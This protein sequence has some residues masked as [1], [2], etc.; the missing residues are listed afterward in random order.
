MKYFESDLNI[1]ADYI[2][3]N[4]F[5]NCSFLVTGATG[6]IGSI[7][8]KSLVLCNDKYKTEIK[9]KATVRSLEKVKEVFS[10]DNF[11][12][13]EFIVQ[14][15]AEQL[16]C[17]GV[18]YLIHTATPTESKFFISNPVET[19]KAICNGSIAVLDFAKNNNV[20]GMVY[21]SSMEVFGSAHTS[22]E[23]TTED[24]LGYID[25]AN[26]RSCYSESKRLV[27]CAC[28]CY[29]EE[30]GVPVKV[31][32]LAQTFGAGISKK[33]NRVF[34]QFARSAL[35]G[36]DIVLHTKGDS[37]GNYCYT[38]DAIKAILLL[39]KKGCNGEAYTV[40]NEQTTMS[41]R[42]MAEMVIKEF[43]NGKIKLKFDI[44]ND[45]KYGYAPKTG[46]RLSSAKLNSLGWRAVVGLKEAYQ[47]MM[48]DL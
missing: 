27:E 5:S 37:V 39:L 48:E 25:I 8:V 15:I 40:V 34:A 23:K 13:I 47:R 19:I 36:S 45:N 17:D 24:Q 38:T 33:E 6:L 32:R 18:D 30:Y 1:L 10:G 28:K 29:A 3:E 14:D 9:I 2:Y 31:A 43:G 16:K 4:G 41:I 21:L 42:E 7:I 46:V 20:K 22:D 26:V 12:Q 11:N 35:S 44:P